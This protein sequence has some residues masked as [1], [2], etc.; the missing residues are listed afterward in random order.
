MEL[1]RKGVVSDFMIWWR[2]ERRQSMRDLAKELDVTTAT[3]Y[4]WA[5]NDRIP[6]NHL[7]RIEEI[8]NNRF[9]RERLRPDLF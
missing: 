1:E 7:R 3:L 9:T 2:V 8:S 5:R 6:L 4:Y